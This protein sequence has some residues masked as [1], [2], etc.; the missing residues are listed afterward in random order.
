M[1]K[2]YLNNHSEESPADIIFRMKI[3]CFK[4]SAYERQ[5]HESVMIQQNRNHQ[6]L[7]SKSEFNRCSLPRL[8]VK[9]GDKEMDELSKTLREEQRKEDELERVIRDLKKQSKKRQNDKTTFQPNAKRSRVENTYSNY[10]GSREHLF[11]EKP[12]QRELADLALDEALRLC[13]EVES[14]NEDINCGDE[15]TP[16]C[17]DDQNSKNNSREPSPEMTIKALLNNQS[18]AGERVVINSRDD[19]CQEATNCGEEGGYRRQEDEM[20]DCGDDQNCRN[21]TREYS[22]EMT[23]KALFNTQSGAG[24][25]VVIR[26]DQYRE[27]DN[28]GDEGGYSGQEDEMTNCGNEHYQQENNCGDDNYQE[29]HSRVTESGATPELLRSVYFLPVE[30][31]RNFLPVEL[32]RNETLAQTFLEL[33]TAPVQPGHLGGLLCLSWVSAVLLGPLIVQLVLCLVVWCTVVWLGPLSVG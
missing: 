16:N 8:T 33:L 7:N 19:Q 29:E 13:E 5:I 9:L 3:V 30:L 24:E 4:R 11:S 17:G 23:I 1:L 15:M 26:D 10:G 14:S 27:A 12:E 18:G 22:P 32:V 2:H 31:V 28:C 21:N 6:L 20:A 25:R